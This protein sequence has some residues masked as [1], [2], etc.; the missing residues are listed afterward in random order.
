MSELHTLVY[1]CLNLGMLMTLPYKHILCLVAANNSRNLCIVYEIGKLFLPSDGSTHA[2]GSYVSIF[3]S[4][5]A[6][7]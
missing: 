5:Q 7:V 3:L 4:P 6:E 2:W 1:V